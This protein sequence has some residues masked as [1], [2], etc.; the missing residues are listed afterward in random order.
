MEDIVSLTHYV[1]DIDAF[2]T[3]GDVRRR[4]FTEPY[5]VTTTVQVERLYHRG[6]R[7]RDHGDRG[8][9]P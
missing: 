5:P 2:M 9:S 3:T 4:F 6:P 7:G 1:T 8:D